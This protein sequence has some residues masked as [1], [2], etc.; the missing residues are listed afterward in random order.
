MPRQQHSSFLYVVSWEVCN[1]GGGV[2]T[3]LATSAPFVDSHYGREL[4]YLGPDLWA[5]RAAQVDF[6]EDEVQ[7]AL[8]AFAEE[9]DVPVRF[10]RWKV[11]DAPPAALVDFGR[12][13][14]RK[15]KV[16]GDLWNEFGVDSIHA[17]WD[18]V[19]RILFGYAAGRLIELHYHATVRP[20]A[21]RAVAHFHQWMAA[22]GLLRLAQTTP[23]VATVYTPHG[24]A[25]GRGFA[26][27]G[28]RLGT[29]L[30]GIEPASAAKE[31]G[32][33]GRHTLEAAAAKQ[34]S[35]L[36]VVSEHG[37][38]E[39]TH[40]LG[41]RPDAVTPN[42]YL[43]RIEPDPAH[44]SEVRAAILRAAERFVGTPLDPAA[45]RVVFSSG[46]YEFH[47]KGFD[48]AIRALGRLRVRKQRPSRHLVFLL[49]SSAPQ[50]GLRHEVMVRLR[51]D[52]LKGTP[53]GICTHNLAHVDEDP[54]C[55]AAREAGIEN[56]PEDPV[57]LIFV[58]V[59]LN[60]RDPLFPYS[61]NDILQASDVSVF[62][63]LYEPW[64]YTPLESLAA[65][66]PTVTTDVTGFGRFVLTL[67]KEEREAVSVLPAN[68]ALV[69]ALEEELIRFLE[70]PD[71]ELE[72]LGRAGS[73]VVERTSWEKLIAKTLDAHRLALEY[74]GARRATRT[75]VPGYAGLS[76]RSLVAVHARSEDRPRLHGFTVATTL[77]ERIE[78]LRELAGNLWWTWNDSARELFATIDPEAFAAM[79][80]NPM[81]LLRTGDAG[82]LEA[83][84][85]DAAFLAQ[86][87]A[88][89]QD[90]DEY[91]S[92]PSAEAPATAYFCAEFAL[93]ESL[94]IFSGGLGVLAGDHLKSAS[95]L[96]LPLTA[97][98]LHYAHGYF[99]QRIQ[100]DGTQHAEFHRTDVRDTP[101]VEVTDDEGRPLRIAITLPEHVIRARVWRVDV[102][103]VPLYLL[104][105]AIPE[106]DPADREVTDRLYPSDREPRLRQELLLGIGGW[107]VLKAV[108]RVPRVCHL[109]EGHSAF[110]LLER[111]L[112]LIENEGLTYDE[113]ATVVRTS[114]L[115]TT[116][117][118]VPAGHDRFPEGLMR[119]YFGH[120]AHRLGLDWEE[121]LDLGRA[122]RDDHEFSMTVLALKLSGRSN[123]VSTLHR[124]VSRRMLANVWPGVHQA[125]T[126]VDSV[127]NGVHLATW[128]GPEIDQ[129]LRRRLSPTWARVHPNA[130]EW[131][132]TRDI[133]DEE[134]WDAHIAQKTR[135]VHFLRESVEETGLRREEKPAR[136]RR[137]LAG[138]DEDALWIGFARRFAP[139][140]RAALVFQDPSRLAKLLAHADRPVRILFA[141]K[142]HPDDRE[143][144]ELVKSIVEMTTDP[145][146]AGRVFF[147]EDYDIA[148]ARLLVQGVE[149]WL[150]TPTRPLEAS[151]TSGMKACLNGVLHVSVL[152]GWW[153]E[154]HDG[155][156]GWTFGEG[157]EHESAELQTEYDSRSLYGL[158]EKRIVPLFFERDRTGLPRRW[159]ERMK[160]TL[161]TIPGQFNTHRMLEDY[162]RT[163]YAPLAAA[164][165]ELERDDYVGARERAGRYAHLREAWRDV[166]I[167]D[168]SVTDP[169]RGSIG[170][171]E[172]FEVRAKVRLGRLPPESVAVE[173]YVG[174]VDAAGELRDPV[175]IPLLRDGEAHDGVAEYTGAYMP[176]GA[177]SFEY[178]VRVLPVV[179]SFNEAAHLGLV[180]WA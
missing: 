156:N 2:H 45:T 158:L 82:K 114:T 26:G 54:V 142:S 162:V 44:R 119:R 130:E 86:H 70:M 110:L 62:P 78:R 11:D 141:G 163:A 160:H 147:I 101:L 164:L 173:L 64:G 81:R 10:G 180:R 178:G 121:F 167:E 14:E 65:G 90:F 75:T 111:L 18:T 125:E 13:L 91:L 151:G 49:F 20:R 6:V 37:T 143:G 48:V 71:E 102:G 38:Q 32:I 3:V 144:G 66:V 5:E 128:A 80:G 43:S 107:R 29:E 108:G 139:Y 88:V 93:H 76:R 127:T 112:D 113:A 22:A 146:F 23:E 138:M 53:C 87:D 85:G 104:D 169:S 153:C 122:S 39:A 132:A 131:R 157:R 136:L 165:T 68:G 137:R 67:P 179:D 135:M 16:L 117:T 171:G 36:T 124:V 166:H 40:L 19:E 72:A 59:M 83:A 41:R 161:A 172:V 35:V 7:P 8:A 57:H 55:K 106:N 155:L 149:V 17:D 25:L 30:L 118:S 129:L 56:R 4:L 52:E 94:P 140:K 47:N 28:L 154:G 9:R 175:V 46:R 109:N 97:I 95:D 115:F 176:E 15:N 79:R 42:G 116:H 33:E 99:V 69:E 77:P 100:P 105:A 89:L 98:G 34:A 50:T 31:R 150:N 92:T 134:I 168:L 1:P 174:P 152:D 84:A 177:G 103:R 126:P 60:Q 58:P 51:R 27:E 74:A 133:P 145:R 96:R 63:S 61:Y 148:V 12:L 24:T 21:H 73:A 120:V 159:I 123:G 170:V